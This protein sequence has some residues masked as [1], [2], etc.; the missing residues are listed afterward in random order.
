MVSICTT[1]GL[2]AAATA[3]MGSVPGS[4]VE[5]ETGATL[6]LSDRASSSA[7]RERVPKPIP[8][9]PAI[10]TTARMTFR[11]RWPPPPLSGEGCGGRGGGGV[12]G[13]PQ[14]DPASAVGPDGLTGGPRAPQGETAGPRS[15]A[16][17]EEGPSDVDRSGGMGG[18]GGGGTSEVGAARNG[19]GVSTVGGWSVPVGEEGSAPDPLSVAAGCSVVGSSPAPAGGAKGERGSPFSGGV[20]GGSFSQLI[21]EAPGSARWAHRGDDGPDRRPPLEHS[22]G[23][24]GKGD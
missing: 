12:G 18:G 21:G 15:G 13:P 4:M 14:F 10:T 24:P 1:E 23:E 20:V 19:L 6:A 17:G 8:N 5:V 9:N 16:G 2:T 11:T 3:A 7:S 22:T